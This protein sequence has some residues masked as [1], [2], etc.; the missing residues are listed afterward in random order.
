MEPSFVDALTEQF[1]R[2]AREMA[3]RTTAD[4]A[5]SAAA[6]KKRKGKNKRSKGKGDVNQR[7]KA[8]AADLLILIE[9]SCGDDGECQERILPCVNPLAV[10]DFSGFVQCIQDANNPQEP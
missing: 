3:S 8:Q 9:I 10:C 6:K 4:H 2:A 1:A 7:C 5:V